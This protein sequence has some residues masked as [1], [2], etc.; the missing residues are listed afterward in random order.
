MEQQIWLTGFMGTGKTRIARPLAAALDWQALDLDTLIEQE[1]GETVAQI[2]ERGGEAAFRT[3]ESQ[4]VERV[5]K[6][7]KVVVA[8]GGGTV[9][10]ESN[11][12]AMRVRGFVVCLEARPETIALRISGSERHISERPLLAG[13]DPLMKITQLKAERQRAYA[14][15]DFILQT[16]DL[17]ADQCTHQILAAFRERQAVASGGHPV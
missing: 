7:E 9:L 17:T 14:D 1:A 2:F 8:T 6:M 15:A 5:A 13:D 3:L 4:I 12:A 11:R 10:A 16:D